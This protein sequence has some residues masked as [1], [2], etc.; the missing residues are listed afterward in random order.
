MSMSSVDTLAPAVVEEGRTVALVPNQGWNERIQ[1]AQCDKFVRSF[2]IRSERCLMLHDTMLGPASG[3]WLSAWAQS[4]A[5]R[6]QVFI[7]NSHADWD[8]YWGNQVFF[9]PIIGSQISLERIMGTS[10]P[11][12]LALKKAEFPC[13]QDVHL[14]PPNILFSQGGL[15]DGGDDVT[16]HF[17]S[18]P[19]HSRDHLSLWL[20][21]ISSLFPADAVEDPF[22]SLDE[23]GGPEVIEEEKRTLM[24]LLELNPEWVFPSHAEPHKGCDLL[25]A[26]LAYIERLLETSRQV[27]EK[28]QGIEELRALFP[29][30]APQAAASYAKEHDRALRLSLS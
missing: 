5:G 20:P 27:R 21:E 4:Q 9:A 3:E 23:D 10:G 30:P 22:P 25:R 17:L 2:L 8:H 6:R 24:K 16:F 15:I 19:G 18:T 1:V 13:Y 29:N 11:K 7:Y 12:E 28:Q 14:T 26:N